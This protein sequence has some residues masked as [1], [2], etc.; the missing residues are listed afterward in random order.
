MKLAQGLRLG[1]LFSL[2]AIAAAPF[3]E[4]ANLTCS[5]ATTLDALVTCIRNQMPGNGSNGFVAPTTAQQADWRTAVHQMLQGSCNFAL[6][7]SLSSIMQIRTFSDSENGKDYCLLMEVLDGNG[8]GIVD[9]GWGTFIVDPAATREISH[10]AAHPIYDIGTE[11]QAVGVFKGTD[12]RSYLMCGAHRLANSASSS[13]QSSYGSADCAHNVANM[14]QSTNQELLS[15]YGA[16]EWQAIQ[17]HGMA[18][19]TCD[20]VDAYLSHGRSVSPQPGDKNLEL[21]N[22][23]LGYHPTW[24]LEC[25]GTG[26]CSLNAT[27]N[28]QGRLLN[29]VPAGSACG[30]AA[31][32][33]SGIFLSIEQDPGFRTASD[34]IPAVQDT[35]PT[36]AP[37][38]PAA[39]T[40]LTATPGN[41]QVSLAWTASS[42]AS[43]YSAHRST[44]SGGPYTTV[45]TGIAGTG[46]TDTGLTNGTTYHYVVTAVNGSGESPNSNQASA[47]PQA[48]QPPPAPTNL[49]ATSPTKRKIS[50][51]W[52]AVPGATSYR[53]KRSSVSGGPY[54]LIAS[55][56]GA[57]YT[58]TGL[59]SGTTY[60]YVVSAVNAAGES[61]DSAQA[62]A[63]AR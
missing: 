18:V 46:H 43:S 9:R 62:S 26:A 30:T 29:G 8:N 53:V 52:T 33:Y 28:T 5:S 47:T 14:F 44:V 40:G 21:T 25:P 38:P 39:P 35:W 59:Q 49:S 15:F 19:D 57:S 58:N 55:P 61:P 13:C 34:W 23:M 41:Q 12:S 63:T 54:T 45:A 42:G 6:P 1:I 24:Q 17:W 31:S 36:G 11:N 32:S 51:T 22:N 16:S 3:A 7:A 56:T 37:T 4:G 27:D 48:P 10:Q 20:G 60:Y 50:L 2:A